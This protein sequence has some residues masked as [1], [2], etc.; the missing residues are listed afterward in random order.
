MRI[1]QPRNCKAIQR[2][3]AFPDNRTTNPGGRNPLWT[4][5]IAGAVIL[6]T[7]IGL[8]F[9]FLI[10]RSCGREH[11]SN[12]V[13]GQAVE[14]KALSNATQQTVAGEIASNNNIPRS[15]NPSSQRNDSEVAIEQSQATPEVLS[16]TQI[17]KIRS[18]ADKDMTRIA[19]HGYDMSVYERISRGFYACSS[20]ALVQAERYA[21]THASQAVITSRVTVVN[22]AKSRGDSPYYSSS[23]A[24]L[25]EATAQAVHIG[26]EKSKTPLAIALD[27]AA[28]EITAESAK[29][30]ALS[31]SS[32]ASI[33]DKST[34]AR[35]RSEIEAVSTDH[36]IRRTDRL[37]GIACDAATFYA[38]SIDRRNKFTERLKQIDDRAASFSS[39]R[40]ESIASGVIRL[41]HYLQI[42]SEIESEGTL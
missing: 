35:L 13:R 9:A 16:R 36:V 27:G 12:S 18:N 8:L 38:K 34:G 7:A 1:D 11:E 10:L 31:L 4:P 41:A 20:F 6:C 37:I 24:L 22:Y 5:I 2:P 15:D 21:E 33:Q 17:A 26:L 19:E 30:I 25:A 3:E 32:A 39:N 40:Y 28:E 23:I 42:I 29:A 14:S